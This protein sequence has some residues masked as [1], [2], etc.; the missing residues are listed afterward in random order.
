MSASRTTERIASLDFQR[1]P[2]ICLMVLSGQT[3]ERVPPQRARVRARTSGRGRGYVTVCGNSA[4]C[5]VADHSRQDTPALRGRIIL[6]VDLLR[7]DAPHRHSR[8]E[9]TVVPAP[10]PVAEGRVGFLT[11]LG[12]VVSGEIL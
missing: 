8:A 7:I 2:A 4:L 10:C 1:G 9:E 11:S 12:K 5:R 3:S 6:G